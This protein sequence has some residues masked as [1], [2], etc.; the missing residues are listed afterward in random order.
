MLLTPAISPFICRRFLRAPYYASAYAFIAYFVITLSP[1]RH[2]AISSIINYFICVSE[3]HFHFHYAT[4]RL[5]H[6]AADIGLS[7]PPYFRQAAIC[8]H[9]FI[10]PITPFIR[11]MPRY[12]ISHFAATL[13]S[14]YYH[15]LRRHFRHIFHITP[16]LRLHFIIFSSLR[17][18][19]HHCLFSFFISL[20]SY[21]FTPPFHY[22][23]PL[24]SFSPCRAIVISLRRISDFH[25]IDLL[26]RQPR[27]YRAFIDFILPHYAISLLRYTIT[28]CAD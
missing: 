26:M 25:A 11:L 24:F 6:Y 2:F 16:F 15:W 21:F 10:L 14:H 13:F 20:F 5:D 27:H 1:F 3:F 28:G 22:D 8:F 17:L 18:R 9:H 23:T 19:L 12:I 7:S 4:R